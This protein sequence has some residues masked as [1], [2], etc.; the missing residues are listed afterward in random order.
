MKSY[1]SLIPISA[2]V[3]KK[4]GKMIMICIVLAVFLVTAI[5]SLVDA[6]ARMETE[7]V[8]DKGGYWHIY[9]SGIGEDEAESIAKR[10]DVAVSSWYEVAN[11]DE[12][13]KMSKDYYIQG[14]QTALC[15]IEQSFIGDIMHF[16]DADAQVT[17]EDAVI[18]TENAQELLGVSKGDTVTLNTP[19]GIMYFA[20]R[21]FGLAEM[22]NMSPRT[23]GRKRH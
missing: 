3:R 4:Q 11:L 6:F 14:A 17:D 10:P 22:A 13:L 15:G 7:N 23:A 8:I 5:F 16:F 12:H 1:L 21:G 18:L 20:Y 2:R 19:A 9:I